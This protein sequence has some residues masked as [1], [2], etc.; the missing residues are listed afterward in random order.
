MTRLVVLV[1][2]HGSQPHLSNQI[3]QRQTWARVL[4]EGVEVFWI[5]EDIGAATV[6]C[7]SDR[8]LFVPVS[9]E[10]D[11]TMKYG[12]SVEKTGRAMRWALDAFQPNY[13]LRTNTSSYFS[14]DL[15]LA[16]L[17]ELPESGVYLGVRCTAQLASGRT[18]EF[19]SGAC[20]LFTPDTAEI[21]SHA[22][23]MS[24]RGELEDVVL[25]AILE[26]SGIKPTS[27]TRIGLEYGEP[28]A[29]GS[30]V[31]LKSFITDNLTVERMH[32][33]HEVFSCRCKDERTERLRRL[34]IA[35][36]WRLSTESLKQALRTPNRATVRQAL[37]RIPFGYWYVAERRRR[38]LSL[39][40]RNESFE[41]LFPVSEG[42][43]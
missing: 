32:D 43:A 30:F 17:T 36:V 11:A 12:T 21:I 18:V 41:Q 20:A 14:L 40:A 35:E 2:A 4:P 33:V 3:A 13:L 15:L 22:G 39:A 27:G 23:G 9:R 10:E 5:Y 24:Y 28:L 16:E 7:D 25:G 42:D 19:I 31:R 1:L 6:S 29:A 38:A 26:S 37:S 34:D 8:N